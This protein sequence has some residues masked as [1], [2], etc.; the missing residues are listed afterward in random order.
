MISAA[1]TELYE[2]WL[3][4]CFYVCVYMCVLYFE[5]IKQFRSN[6]M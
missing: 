1:N 3:L 5:Q 4:V 6:T 2:K